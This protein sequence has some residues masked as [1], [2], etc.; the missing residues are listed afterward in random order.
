MNILFQ[1]FLEILKFVI[2]Q[3]LY[4]NVYIHIGLI[5]EKTTTS[6]SITVCIGSRDI[7]NGKSPLRDAELIKKK[8]WS[9]FYPLCSAYVSQKV[10]NKLSIMQ[11]FQLGCNLIA[12]LSFFRQFHI[13]HYFSIFYSIVYLNDRRGR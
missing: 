13:L 2:K 10:N 4:C 11:N 5:S 7:L 3:Y 1:N 9:W 8:F 12:P 6:R